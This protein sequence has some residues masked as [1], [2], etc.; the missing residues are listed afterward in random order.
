MAIIEK[1]ARRNGIMKKR[2]YQ[3]VEV[4]K[5][6]RFMCETCEYFYCKII[7]NYPHSPDDVDAECKMETNGK[8]ESGIGARLNEIWDRMETEA[9]EQESD[10]G[11]GYKCFL[12]KWKLIEICEI[13]KIP[14]DDDIGCPEC[15]AKAMK[16][17]DESAEEW[18]REQER[19]GFAGVTVSCSNCGEQFDEGQVD[20]TDIC[21]DSL[22]QDVVSFDCPKCNQTTRSLR[23]G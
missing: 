17:I 3:K 20:I 15:Y 18:K 2:Y 14:L 10:I 4:S 11:Q 6:T 12:W 9:F 13:H 16:E 5:T 7:F 19:L 23:L 21:E 8:W 1:I 22:G